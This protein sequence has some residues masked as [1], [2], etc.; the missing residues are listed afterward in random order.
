MTMFMYAPF[1]VLVKLAQRVGYS[2]LVILYQRF[3][4][5]YDACLPLVLGMLCVWPTGQCWKYV[6]VFGYCLAWKTG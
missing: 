3:L 1:D 2:I 4:L 6:P 5:Q